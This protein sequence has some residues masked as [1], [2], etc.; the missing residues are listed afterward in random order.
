MRGRPW[1]KG[2]DPRRHK[3]P[4]ANP[5]LKGHDPRRYKGGRATRNKTARITDREEF[6]RF[7]GEL[8][9]TVEM[10]AKRYG[11]SQ[12]TVYN[13]A[14]RFGLPPR[15]PMLQKARLGPWKPRKAA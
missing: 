13:T 3:G 10:I 4:P 5:F 14:K 2:E 1:Q 7:W 11:V 6:A 15:M 12:Q 8:Y 9:N